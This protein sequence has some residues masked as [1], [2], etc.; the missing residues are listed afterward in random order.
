MMEYWFLKDIANFKRAFKTN[1]PIRLEVQFP[2]THSSSIP[3]FHY[4]KKLVFKTLFFIVRK[5]EFFDAIIM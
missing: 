5:N 4:S 3:T 1:F 2:F